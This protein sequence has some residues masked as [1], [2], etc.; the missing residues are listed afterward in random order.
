MAKKSNTM[1]PLTG[2]VVVRDGRRVRPTIGKAFEFEGD[3]I[4]Q[5]KASGAKFRAPTDETD[6]DEGTAAA[7]STGK[8]PSAEASQAKARRG[9][10]PATAAKSDDEA[11][12]ESKDDDL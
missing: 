8:I 6:I 1:V 10:K 5:L 2:T 11:A 9:R 12:S 7:S 3:E 4:E